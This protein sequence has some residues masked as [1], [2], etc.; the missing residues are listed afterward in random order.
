MNWKTW[1]EPEKR[2]RK[3]ERWWTKMNGFKPK[4]LC[5][6]NVAEESVH[7]TLAR[8]KPLRYPEEQSSTLVRKTT[9]FPNHSSNLAYLKNINLADPQ[10]YEPGKIDT[11]IG[12]DLYGILLKS[13]NLINRWLTILN[14]AVY[15]LVRS[16]KFAGPTIHVNHGYMIDN[17]ANANWLEMFWKLEEIIQFSILTA[18]E[19]QYQTFY[20]STT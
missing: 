1:S 9:S 11:I 19:K 17:E 16:I 6:A 15:C 12:V 4:I 2:R 18:D 7:A 14:S 20:E 3:V 13:G 8:K 5:S 10:Y